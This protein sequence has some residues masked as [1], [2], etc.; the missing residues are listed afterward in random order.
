MTLPTNI[1]KGQSKE[2]YVGYAKGAW[3]ITRYY[4]GWQAVRRVH[5]K[6]APEMANILNA[7]TLKEM[8]AKLLEVEGRPFFEMTKPELSQK[9]KE[10]VMD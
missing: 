7:R 9:R 1:A 2:F 8:G 5:L 10:A 3:K 6:C 4:A